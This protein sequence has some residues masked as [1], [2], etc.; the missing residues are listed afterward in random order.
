MRLGKREREA[1]KKAQA[2]QAMHE[3][4][5]R[6]FTQDKVRNACGRWEL[7]SKRSSLPNHWGTKKVIDKGF[8][9]WSTN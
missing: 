6:Y 3:A 1:L 2:I 4:E 8:A 9:R 5:A 7:A